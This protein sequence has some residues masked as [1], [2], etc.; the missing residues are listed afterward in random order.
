MN[1]VLLRSLAILVFGF[2]FSSCDLVA[3]DSTSATYILIKHVGT[4]D[5]PVP[6]LIFTS[7]ES[8]ARQV[9]NANLPGIRWVVVVGPEKYTKM[10]KFFNDEKSRA[11]KIDR[12]RIADEFGVFEI[13]EHSLDDTRL[14]LIIVSGEYAAKFF[15]RG[16]AY[17]ST[18][19]FGPE[20]VGNMNYLHLR[21]K[22]GH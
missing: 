1:S 4:E 14:W 6:A 12:K 22:N 2:C 15:A 9:N 18:E 13:S 20:A 19:S 5:K 3:V 11:P 7:E 21:C 17:F 10:T 8:V 16:S